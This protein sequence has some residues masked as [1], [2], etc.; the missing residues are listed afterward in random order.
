MCNKW[1]NTGDCPYGFKCQF[2][3]GVIE[4]RARPPMPLCIDLQPGEQPQS[5]VVSPLSSGMPT[6]DAVSPPAV[7]PVSNT[8]L[9]TGIQMPRTPSPLKRRKVQFSSIEGNDVQGIAAPTVAS[10]ARENNR[11]SRSS[12]DANVGDERS[13]SRKSETDT[14]LRCNSTTGKV[15]IKPSARPSSVSYTTQNVLSC[16]S[17]V[18]ED[19][20]RKTEGEPEEVNPWGGQEIFGLNRTWDPVH[21]SVATR[22]SS[23]AEPTQSPRKPQMRTVSPQ[24]SLAMLPDELADG[25]ARLSSREEI[26]SATGRTSP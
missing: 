9:A 2:A 4:L 13:S 25:L 17:H 19:S 5:A 10:S 26:D 3:H 24:R 21:K 22:G 1:L 23:W 11:L 14:L 12:D 6:G 18:F 7:S 15:E 20:Q 8:A 16:L